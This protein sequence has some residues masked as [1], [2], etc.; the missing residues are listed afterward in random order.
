MFQSLP[1]LQEGRC[2][3][4]KSD[5]AFAREQNRAVKTRTFLIYLVRTSIVR[6]VGMPQGAQFSDRAVWAECAAQPLLPCPDGTGPSPSSTAIP[7]SPQLPP[8]VRA[9]TSR[10]PGLPDRQPPPLFPLALFWPCRRTCTYRGTAEHPCASSSTTGTPR[11]TLR[12]ARCTVQRSLPQGLHQ[13]GGR[14]TC[15]LT[16]VCTGELKLS[17]GLEERQIHLTSVLFQDKGN[18]EREK[19]RHGIAEPSQ[20]SRVS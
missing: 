19:L 16:P 20:E 14:K 10:V 18:L 1:R 5:L 13:G 3:R 12:R 11:S 17:V 7:T 6:M 9:A 4:Q 15:L 8:A 2:S